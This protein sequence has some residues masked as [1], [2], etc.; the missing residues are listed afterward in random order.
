MGGGRQT[1]AQLKGSVAGAVVQRT[2]WLLDCMAA[3]VDVAVDTEPLFA[4]ASSRTTPTPLDP[5][6][7]RSG[8]LDRRWNVIVAEYPDEEFS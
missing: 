8:T 5:G 4:L 2:G 6:Y 3:Q 7:G 1:I